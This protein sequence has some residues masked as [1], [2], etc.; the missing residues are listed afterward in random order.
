MKERKKEKE[1]KEEEELTSI[2]KTGGISYKV[3]NLPNA[4]ISCLSIEISGFSITA[5]NVGSYEAVMAKIAEPSLRKKEGE[6]KRG[7]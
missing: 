2:A 3:C 6:G 4:L 1:K 5:K 7:R